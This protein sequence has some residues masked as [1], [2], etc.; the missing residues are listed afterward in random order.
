MFHMGHYTNGGAVFCH[1]MS[2]SRPCDVSV[3]TSLT[4]DRDRE[5]ET[6]DFCNDAVNWYDNK[7]RI[8]SRDDE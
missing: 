3:I 7:Q 4:M 1:L 6:V 8:A 5:K 2:K